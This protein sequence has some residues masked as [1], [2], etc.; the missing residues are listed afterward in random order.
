MSLTEKQ[1]EKVFN[2]YKRRLIKRLGTRATFADELTNIGRELFG[3]LYTGTYRQQHKPGRKSRQFFIINTATDGPGDHWVAV[4]KNN[5][6]YYI[7][8]SFARSS[9]KLIPVFARGKLTIDSDRS[10][11]EQ[12]G[13]SQICGQLCLSWLCCVRDLG[14]RN[15]LKI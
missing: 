14:I 15:A 9:K 7:Y 5:K 8:D 3:G 6:T 10:D 2:K 11:A 12:F 13:D 1:V 4:V